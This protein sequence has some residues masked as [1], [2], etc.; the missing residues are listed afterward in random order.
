MRRCLKEPIPE[1]FLAW[2]ALSD[3]VDEH[4]AGNIEA[5]S[6]R[7][8][9]ANSP[10]VWEWL[11][12]S[13]INVEQHV[14]TR[15]PADDTRTVPREQRDPDRTIAKSVKSAVLVRDGYR[16]RYCG[17]P[18]V[19]SD[20]R[21]LA[22]SLYPDSVPWD[23][24]RP[25]QQH[26]GFQVF[27]LQYDHVEPHSHGGRSSVENVVVSC[28]LCN[29]GKDRFTLRQLDLEDPRD[30][31]PVP[32][33][34]DGLERFRAVDRARPFFFPGA[35]ISGGYVST[36]AIAGK[37]RWFELGEN[38]SAEPAV[39]NGVVGYVVTC[40]PDQLKRRG[41]DW[42]AYLDVAPTG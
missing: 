14:V 32:S 22:H 17:L 41:L 36:P 1:I 15:K 42:E 7:F 27:W 4:L 23:S 28:A 29:F 37:T 2:R 11:N 40:R 5:A 9:E 39:R 33:D 8:S 24:R 18:V 19:H 30:R 25:E 6:A 21:K 10:I 26:S 35:K 12:H 20:I 16:C 38:L 31:A 34:F 13:W 3:A